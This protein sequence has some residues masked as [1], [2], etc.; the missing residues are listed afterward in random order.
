MNHL[1]IAPIVLP[2]VAAVLCLLAGERHISAKRAVSLSAVL[3]LAVI[4][5]LLVTMAQDGEIRVYRLGNWPA[6]YGIVLV[7]DR[8]AAMMLAL[9][10]ALALP[11]LLRAIAGSDADG[12]HFH[13]LFLLQIAGLNGAF[14]TGDLFNLFV[15]FEIL[16]LASYALLMHGGGPL[17]ARAGLAY[18]V[19]N[20][21]GSA[22]FL[23]ALGLIYGTL[24]TLTLADV[25][26]VLPTVVGEDQALVRVALLLLAGVFV[27]KAAMVPLGF[28][29]PH[30]YVAANAAVATLFAIMTKVGIYALLRV[31]TIGFG[32]APFSAELLSPWLPAL[33][34]VT[35][36]VG[37]IGALA[38]RQFSGIVANVLLISSGTL[39]VAVAA[40]ESGATAAALYYLPQGTLVAGGLFLLSD[41]LAR[42]RGS[43]ADRLERG[44]RLPRAALPASCFLLLAMAASGIPPLSGFLGK[45]MLMQSLRGN[46]FGAVFWGVLLFTG[47]ALALVFA[48]A[49]STLLWEPGHEATAPPQAAVSAD[50]PEARALPML[51]C[52]AGS[53]AFVLAAAPLARY[54][55]AAAEQL[56][57]REG[58]VSAVL[59]MPSEIKRERR[60]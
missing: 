2:L 18:V 27:L 26:V 39:L 29:L 16:L 19:L 1:L 50:A 9:T 25:A 10:A 38:A 60:P 54:A 32:A 3:A 59:G 33:G 51:L 14:L 57:A 13:A 21:T 22:A 48:R 12:R 58:Y 11:V 40:G 36:M 49:A 23:F 4:A 31:S 42:Q 52:I 44:P 17:R 6:P 43:I 37:V 56:H 46:G 8:L 30:T 41:Y 34:M 5:T 55:Q 28:W 24:G 20:L 45:I 35:M 7:L 47:L 15:F 53:L